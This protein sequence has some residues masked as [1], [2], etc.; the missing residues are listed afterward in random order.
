MGRDGAGR[1]G[2][3][4]PAGGDVVLL[5]GCGGRHDVRGAAGRGHAGGGLEAHERCDDRHSYRKDGAYAGA[6]G[7]LSRV[8]GDET[9]ARGS[10]GTPRG[11]CPCRRCRC[12]RDDACDCVVARSEAESL[13]VDHV[14]NRSVA[15][16]F[17]GK[18]GGLWSMTQRHVPTRRTRRSRGLQPGPPSSSPPVDRLHTPQASRA[19][20]TDRKHG[21][22]LEPR[23]ASPTRVSLFALLTARVHESTSPGRRRRRRRL[24]GGRFRC[25]VTRAARSDPPPRPSLTDTVPLPRV[26]LTYPPTFLRIRSRTHQEEA[27]RRHERRAQVR[28]RGAHPSIAFSF[29]ADG[30]QRRASFPP[31]S[32]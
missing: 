2:R 7:C 27:Q 22:G 15:H 24:P 25:R 1:V 18:S 21:S 9:R 10:S 12:G 4:A 13:C 26:D 20:S 28:G 16:M 6:C 31:Q 23:C 3:G 29:P 19:A 5:D 14:S 8:W 32:R 30:V 11:S 17:N